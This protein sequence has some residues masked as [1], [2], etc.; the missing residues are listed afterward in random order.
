M[1][2][3]AEVIATARRMH[4]L[5]LVTGTFGNVSCRLGDAILIT[6]SGLGYEA[7]TPED[8]VRLGMPGDVLGGVR[9]PSSEFR[10]HVAIYECVEAADAIVHTHS[11]S[12]VRFAE[13]EAVLPA[14]DENTL[15]GPIPVSPF[16]PP[17]TQELAD[18]AAALLVKRGSNAVILQD[19]GVVGVGSNLEEAL[20]VC[21]AVER[22]A[23]RALA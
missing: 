4:G 19:H 15:R 5:G 18:R 14:H 8:L 23:T 20:A 17:G 6:P 9:A 22:A 10:L 12:A 3:H 7:M 13:S 21:R 2:S 11:V 16:A 1:C